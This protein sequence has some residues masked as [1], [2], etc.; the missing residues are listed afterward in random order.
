MSYLR[1]ETD[2]LLADKATTT[3]LTS[4][5]AVAANN[6]ALLQQ[7]ASLNRDIAAEDLIATK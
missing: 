5:Q 2:T 6:L 3:Q 4:V 7:T 1:A